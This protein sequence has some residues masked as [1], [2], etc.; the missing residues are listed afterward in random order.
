MG[1]RVGEGRLGREPVF[2]HE[3]DDRGEEVGGELWA[4]RGVGLGEG[5]GEGE[6]DVVADQ[7]EGVA[8]LRA[9]A[10]PVEVDVEGGALVDQVE[11]LVPEEEVGVAGG[12]VDVRE[13][14]VEPDDR[15]GE[16]GVGSGRYGRVVAEGAGEE[17]DGEVEAGAGL[18]QGL[19]LGV[20]LG[21]AEDGV[22][23][24]EG[25]VGDGQAEGAADRAGD[26]LGDEDLG[27]L[28]G[29]AELEDVGA[30]VVGLDDGRQRAAL[31]QGGDVAGDSDGSDGWAV[32][33]R[34]LKVAFFVL[35]GIS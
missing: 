21:A 9:V 1:G 13:I 15:R 18:D 11:P 22:E 23:R 27:A 16:G 34:K 29:A 5:G 14:G 33:E 28:A 3:V 26:E 2:G 20:G 35:P 19:D 32:Q 30:E 7:G 6:E 12:A 25:D 4:E 24:G 17:V 31:A 10:G 8:D